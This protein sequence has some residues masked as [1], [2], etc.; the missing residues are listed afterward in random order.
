MI[1]SIV[2]AGVAEGESV[3]MDFA[4]VDDLFAAHSAVHAHTRARDNVFDGRGKLHFG[5]GEH[6]FIRHDLIGLHLREVVTRLIGGISIGA[7]ANIGHGRHANGTAGLHIHKRRGNLAVI[8]HAQGAMADGAFCRREE[9]VRETAVRFGDDQRSLFIGRRVETEGRH[10]HKSDAHAKYLAR[11]EVRVVAGGE[12][13]QGLEVHRCFQLSVI[14]GIRKRCLMEKRQRKKR[15][16]LLSKCGGRRC[17]HVHLDYRVDSRAC[18][19][20]RTICQIVLRQA[21]RLRRFSYQ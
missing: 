1:I 9:P 17:F 12:F 21:G 18:Y 4:F 6:F 14:S 13:E 16:I 11:A 10:S 8:L 20:C 7:L 5:D 3:L 19:R 2:R 15:E